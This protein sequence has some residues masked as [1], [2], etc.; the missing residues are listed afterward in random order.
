MRTQ[1]AHPVS[2]RGGE[3]GEVQERPGMR[4][5]LCVHAYVA[6]VHVHGMIDAM[7]VMMIRAEK[8]LAFLPLASKVQLESLAILDCILQC[9][10]ALLAK[11]ADK[12]AY[13]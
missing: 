7:Y 4:T 12:R 8:E 1:T 3:T 11:A 2:H 10:L 5:A 9:L 13:D 6:H